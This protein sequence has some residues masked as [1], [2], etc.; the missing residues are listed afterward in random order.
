MNLSLRHPVQAIDERYR[1]IRSLLDPVG[2]LAINYFK[3]ISTL[4]VEQ[5]MNGQDVVT[6]AD[7]EVEFFLKKAILQT[8]PTDSILGEESGLSAGNN[9]FIWVIDPIDGTSCFVHQLRSWCISIALTYQGKIVMGVVYDVANNE[10]FEALEG[11][12]AY[13]N[14]Q[15]IQVNTQQTLQEGLMGLGANLRV[16]PDVSARFADR[17][18]AQK[19]MFYRNGSCALM[20]SYVACGR[21]IGYFE[22]HVNS[23]DCF[24]G[25]LLIQEAGGWTSD[26]SGQEKLLHGAEISAGALQIQTDLT[27]LITLA[28][29][30]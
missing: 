20:L 26:F 3:Q 21:L 27:Q 1:L 13:L 16:G 6:K 14:Q 2:D 17:L 25:L 29:Q 5:K 18:L 22:P 23:W 12:G 24:A 30:A 8:F 10:C 7:K 19:G 28:H 4:A 11:R 15:P 9:E